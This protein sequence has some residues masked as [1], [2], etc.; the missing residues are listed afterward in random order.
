VYKLATEEKQQSAK[1]SEQLEKWLNKG[2][3]QCELLNNGTELEL[4]LKDGFRK[5][6]LERQPKT[7][8]DR[9]KQEICRMKKE[10]ERLMGEQRMF[11]NYFFCDWSDKDRQHLNQE[12]ADKRHDLISGIKFLYDVLSAKGQVDLQFGSKAFYLCF[13]KAQMANLD[14]SASKKLQQVSHMISET[15]G[16]PMGTLGGPSHGT[17]G[18]P[19]DMFEQVR[20]NRDDRKLN[21][22]FEGEDGS[23]T[24]DVFLD[25]GFYQYHKAKLDLSDAKESADE[26]MFR[27]N[28]QV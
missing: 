16:G 3:Y 6:T 1:F 8:M 10:N 9:M 7:D 24:M 12:P 2:K 28:C 5:Y 27:V 19:S 23:K 4:S 17:L 11:R 13:D 26:L 14:T 18:G 20:D 25:G 22:Y 21:S 15:A